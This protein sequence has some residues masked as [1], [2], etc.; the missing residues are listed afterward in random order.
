[1]K[2]LE[3]LFVKNQNRIA[4]VVVPHN[5]A[6]SVW[7]KVKKDLGLERVRVLMAQTYLNLP[8]AQRRCDLLIVD[9]G[10]RFTNKDAIV[11]S[12][13]IEET[14]NRFVMIL[15]A[16]FSEEQKMFMH[17]LGIKE[18]ANVS[19]KEATLCEY[20][21][22]HLNHWVNCNLY[23]EN[24]RA[25]NEL[26]EA[27]HSSW[28]PF[29]RNFDKIRL[30]TQP[31]P[32][33]DL[34]RLHFSQLLN[35]PPEHLFGMAQTALT[36]MQHRTSFLRK[37]PA[38]ID[39][40]SDICKIHKGKKI[41]TFGEYTDVADQLSNVLGKTSRSYHS[42][43]PSTKVTRTKTKFWKTEKARDNFFIKNKGKLSLL[44]TVAKC[45]QG[46]GVSWKTKKPVSG[47][48][49]AEENMKLFSTPN[50]GVDILN[51]CKSL[52]EAKDIDGVEV[53]IIWSFSS[54]NRQMVQ[55]FG[56][57][58]RWAEGKEAYLYFLVMKRP[59]ARTQEQVWAKSAT[60]G[61]DY[62]TINDYELKRQANPNV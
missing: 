44:E 61:I 26:D 19:M 37:A 6:K 16:T 59:S 46:Y 32:E 43:I 2:A 50:S 57:T 10:H 41:I 23:G 11:F 47:K 40:V 62:L 12:K 3:E 45:D 30:C 25:I 58:I 7:L 5:A 53:G 8:T 49:I 13:I 55:R 54:K 52:D 56:R 1:M 24:L 34:T 20:V 39:V 29:E 14:K 28:E 60:K 18:I 42:S 27:F 33:G 31:T 4:N 48:A 35:I 15:S 38:K 22:K 36:A 51:T 21:A 9:E 17:K